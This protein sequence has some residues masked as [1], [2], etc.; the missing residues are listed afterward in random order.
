MSTSS[1]Q[2]RP[3]T[4]AN[5]SS[6]PA[7]P[8]T[9]TFESQHPPMPTNADGNLRKRHVSETQPE[10]LN[11]SKRSVSKQRRPRTTQ[12]EPPVSSSHLSIWKDFCS[13][14]SALFKNAQSQLEAL[15]KKKAATS[16][17]TGYQQLL[18]R[19]ETLEES[20]RHHHQFVENRLHQAQTMDLPSVHLIRSMVGAE[21]KIINAKVQETMD[22]AQVAMIVRVDEMKHEILQQVSMD[23][24][25]ICEINLQATLVELRP[26]NDKITA[27]KEDIDKR[28][29]SIERAQHMLPE[30]MEL[31]KNVRD[32][33]APQKDHAMESDNAVDAAGREDLEESRASEAREDK[34]RDRQD[35]EDIATI[36]KSLDRGRKEESNTP[37]AEQMGRTHKKETFSP[38]RRGTAQAEGKGLE[39]EAVCKSGSKTSLTYELKM[40]SADRRLYWTSFAKDLKKLQAIA[41]Q[42]RKRLFDKAGREEPVPVSLGNQ[43]PSSSRPGV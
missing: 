16:N 13:G 22:T 34:S 7:P 40:S 29:Q 24:Q 27:V 43:E 31:L 6:N 3:P 5:E 30:I 23:L 38:G 9:T 20:L 35:N 28:M 8:T 14:G 37:G 15:Q 39:D 33:P 17:D 21:A 1:N 19:I 4:A 18:Q 26:L 2:T 41:Q 25:D 32:E 36:S 12:E 11:V 10:T 42:G